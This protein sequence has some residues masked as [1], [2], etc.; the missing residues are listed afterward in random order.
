MISTKLTDAVGYFLANC[1]ADEYLC[2][3][4]YFG[5]LQGIYLSMARSYIDPNLDSP[6]GSRPEP[7]RD[8]GT[9]DDEKQCKLKEGN[10]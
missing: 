8:H 4:F 6:R 10:Q 9:I 3:L 7:G 5:I 2:F 1:F